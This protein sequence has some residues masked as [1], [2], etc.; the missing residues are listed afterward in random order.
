[1]EIALDSKQN[2][3]VDRCNFD[4][5]QRE[6][7]CAIAK[8]RDAIC[9]AVV[10]SLPVQ[11]C[12]QRASQRTEHEGGVTGPM[13]HGVVRRIAKLLRPPVPR[14]LSTTNCEYGQSKRTSDLKHD[15]QTNK[16]GAQTGE[17][18][19]ARVWRCDGSIS[20]V[21]NTLAQVLEFAHGSKSAS[22]SEATEQQVAEKKKRGDDKVGMQQPDQKIRKL[23]AGDGKSGVDSYAEQS[24]DKNV[25]DIVKNDAME[26]PAGYKADPG[27]WSCIACT[28]WNTKPLAPVCEVCGT[29]KNNQQR[30]A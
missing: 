21:E 9:A 2:V 15:T 5:N 10:L 6:S 13:A 19:I 7:F 29:A 4:A 8:E 20:Q 17:E 3:I 16:G 14:G 25:I 18:D 12:A 22:L 28:F 27:A 26:E 24:A 23:S 1:M 30:G 11:V